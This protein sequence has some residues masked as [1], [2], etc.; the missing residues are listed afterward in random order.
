MSEKV[1]ISIGGLESTTAR[2]KEL[3]QNLKRFSGKT[4][5][6]DL[7]D[8]DWVT[9]FSI[10]P[11]AHRISKIQLKH[12]VCLCEP[13]NLKV[14]TY[15]ETI[16]FPQGTDTLSKTSYS[17]TYMPIFRIKLSRKAK[18]GAGSVLDMAVGEYER[19]LLDYLLP[20]YKYKKSLSHALKYFI[21]EMTTNVHEHSSADEFWIF[22]QYWGG[23]QE[24]EICLLDDGV[25][26]QGSY[27]QA[28]IPT[29]DDMDA[30][31]KALDGVSAKQHK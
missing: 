16:H 10:L 28:G 13:E 9:P 6:V 2:I 1:S 7:T 26:L 29:R 25:G 3:V 23:K 21:S 12:P 24:L 19:I 27:N 17:K 5:E 14:K 22:A 20:D 18:A 30:L 4:S 8:A 15:L 11:L 31:Q